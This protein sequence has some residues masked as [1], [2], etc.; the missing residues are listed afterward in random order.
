MDCLKSKHGQAKNENSQNTKHKTQNTNNIQL[1]IY[2]IPKAL[3][4]MAILYF[5]I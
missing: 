5:G 2:Q 1:P 4:F 3:F